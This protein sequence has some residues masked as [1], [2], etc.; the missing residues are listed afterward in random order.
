[1]NEGVNNPKVRPFTRTLLSSSPTPIFC[2]FVHSGVEEWIHLLDAMNS[3]S[4]S[5][6]LFPLPGIPTLKIP[7]A[8]VLRA[9]YNQNSLDWFKC[10]WV[11][12]KFKKK[13]K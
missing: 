2:P 4:A 7:H 3:R 9:Y 10:A 6:Y 13:G 5:L 12:K 11:E 8:A 1:M